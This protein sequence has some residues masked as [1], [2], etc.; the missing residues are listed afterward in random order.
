MYFLNLF[1]FNDTIFNIISS[2]IFLIILKILKSVNL[3]E[4]KDIILKDLDIY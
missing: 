4:M 3:W 2:L 1:Y